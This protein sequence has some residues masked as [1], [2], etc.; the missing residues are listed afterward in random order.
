[1]ISIDI[2]TQTLSYRGKTYLISSAKNGVGE[3][4]GSYCTPRGRFQIA[5]KIG[6]GLPVGSVLVGREPTGEIYHP[7]LVKAQPDRDWILTRILWLDGLDKSNQNTKSRYIYIH[8]SPEQTPM[9]VP[10]SKGCIRMRNQDIVELFDKVQIA[11]DVVIIN[12]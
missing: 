5:K 4:E 12:S 7:E 10:G 1:M 8:G 3:V 2:N 11:E 6:D 9:G